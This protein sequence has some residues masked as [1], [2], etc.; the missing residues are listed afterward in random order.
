VDS[1]VVDE[2]VQ[3]GRERTQVVLTPVAH[4]L[5][6]ERPPTLSWAA[7]RLTVDAST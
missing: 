4:R 5:L 7:W 3:Q 1:G 6:E 2:A